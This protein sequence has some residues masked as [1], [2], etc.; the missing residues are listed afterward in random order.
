MRSSSVSW[1]C[2]SF[3]CIA[4]LAGGGLSAGKAAADPNWQ[5]SNLP[6][7]VLNVASDGSSLWACGADEAIAVSTDGG[8]HWQLRHQAP[9]GNL[10]L[11]MGFANEK[12]GYAAGTGGLLLM[13]EDGGTTWTP[14]SANGETVLQVS[15]ADAKTGLIRTADRLLFTADGGA[16]WSAVSAGANGEALKNFPYSFSLVALDAGHMAIMLKSGAAQYES[17]VFL[18]TA[19]GGKTWEKVSIPN[20]TLYSFLRTKGEYWTI[21]TEVVGK[22]KPGGGHAVPV[23]LYSSDGEKWVHSTSDLSACGP[24]MCVACTGQ[25][26]LSANGVITDVFAEK[27]GN[28]TFPSNPKLTPKWAATRTSMCYVGSSLQCAPLTAAT[29]ATRGEGTVPPVVGPGPLG[30]KASQGPHCIA[31][32]I[33]HFIADPKVQGMFAFKLVLVIGRDGT[34]KEVEADGAPTPEIKARIEQQAQQW[35]FEPYL[36][37]GVRVDLKLTT[38]VQ[39]A[40][41]RPR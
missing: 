41:M 17:Q 36:K 9:D 21:G 39:V 31:C 25:G 22:D 13:T 10:L 7:R 16:N 5:P 6:F 14:R 15:F 29:Q 23:A 34:V 37:D 3:I 20:V 18:T 19:D 8:T 1:I 2:S 27:P 33:D 35:I 30:A 32:E 24:E 4:I 38:E 11:S 26:C 40:V 28:W 12:F